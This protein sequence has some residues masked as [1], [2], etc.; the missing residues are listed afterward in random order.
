MGPENASIS[1]DCDNKEN[2]AEISNRDTATRRTKNMASYGNHAIEKLTDS[3]YESWKIQMK[4][5]L[6]CNDLWQYVSGK[7]EKTPENAIAWENKDEKAL[8][9]I[10]LGVSS[11][12]LNHVKK[13]QTSQEAWTVLERIHESRG[14]IRKAV[15]YRQLYKLKKEENQNMAEFVTV[16]QSKAE[17]LEE[18]GI[19][20]PDELLSIMLLNALPT[21]YASFCVAIESRDEVPSIDVLKVKLIEQEARQNEQKQQEESEDSALL[22]KE[23]PKPK[24]QN[25]TRTQRARIQ[26][27]LKQT[28][29]NQ[30]CFKCNR[31]GHIAANCRT[32]QSSKGRPTYGRGEAMLAEMALSTESSKTGQWYLDSGAT[33]HMCNDRGKFEQFDERYNAQ[34]L[35]AAKRPL[36]SKGIGSVRMRVS[37]LGNYENDINLR[38]T[39]YVPEFRN[40]LVSVARITESGYSVNFGKNIATV[41]RKNGTVAMIAKREGDL[42]RVINKDR[43]VAQAAE[44]RKTDDTLK[45][46]RRFGHLNFDDLKRLQ[47][48]NMVCGLSKT[49]TDSLKSC[50]TCAK[51][52]IHQ[53]SHP[54]STRRASA[55]LELIHSDI[56]GPMNLPSLGGARYFITFIDDKTRYCEV[57]ML[58]QKSDA[59]QAFKEY[60]RRVERQ[61]GYRVKTL[62][63]DNGREYMSGE[64]TAFLKT[65]GIK[66]ELTVQYTPQQNGVAERANRT[67]VEMARCLIIESGLP[68]SLWAEA[69]N[70]AVFLRNRCPTKS[71]DKM[72][73]FEAWT[74]RKPH[75]GFLRTFGS[76]AI[77]LIKGHRMGKFQAKGQKCVMVGYSPESK[78]YRLWCPGTKTVIKGCDVRFL[79][80]SQP[81]SDEQEDDVSSENEESPQIAF[82]PETVT[83]EDTLQQQEESETMET[84]GN[85]EENFEDA[86]EE[87]STPVKRAPG[88]PKLLRTGKVG[89]PRRI[90]QEAN[91]AEIMDPQTVEEVLGREDKEL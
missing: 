32:N 23:K 89:R 35:T 72:T 2:N 20:I 41:R 36:E 85:E 30:T 77:T 65:L 63:T 18:A 19:T 53:V 62:R 55:V 37:G 15:L 42:Y 39:I 70:T 10:I 47:I 57:K 74:G 71:L 21:Q 69:V 46:H 84:I 43:H 76:E 17:Q 48:E 22:S 28:R 67:I 31:K 91:T 26:H 88:R 51:A 64:F 44:C 59:L 45:W 56:C 75:V 54:P 12:Q 80:N 60:V 68:Q 6:I 87:I 8:A 25:H 61:T 27:N 81:V 9:Q 83:D 1:A 5:I 78:A 58:K 24:E 11:L 73:P 49:L 66:R 13:A 3:N 82:I 90:Y 50:E 33:K 34:V 52:K 7:E 86:V 79:E 29:Y 16:F 4:S 38:N 14:P 40:N